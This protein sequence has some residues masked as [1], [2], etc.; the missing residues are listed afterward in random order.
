VEEPEVGKSRLV[1]WVAH[2][3]YKNKE[4]KEVTVESPTGNRYKALSQIYERLSLTG[5][6]DEAIRGL[7]VQ[8][9]GKKKQYTLGMSL[10]QATR[11]AGGAS[12]AKVQKRYRV[13]VYPGPSSGAFRGQTLLAESPEEALLG[14]MGTFGCTDVDKLGPYVVELV[15]RTGNVVV[16]GKSIQTFNDVTIRR[17]ITPLNNVVNINTARKPAPPTPSQKKFSARFTAMLKEERA[18]PRRKFTIVRS[19]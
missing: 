7:M 16:L 12:G 11:E 1:K 18:T 13:R 15:G 6:N 4:I 5:P 2:V 9:E 3:Y 17:D 19:V 14:V 10:K 8:E